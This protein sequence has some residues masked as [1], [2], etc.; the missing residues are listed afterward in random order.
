MSPGDGRR[1]TGVIR[2]GGLLPGDAET[3]QPGHDVVGLRRGAGGDYRWF[4]V[5]YR[6]CG[7]RYGG[8]KDDGR[9][10]NLINF[11]NRQETLV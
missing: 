6:Y 8:G 1:Q 7:E 9:V 10:V 5:K 4:I 11:E 2:G 3:G